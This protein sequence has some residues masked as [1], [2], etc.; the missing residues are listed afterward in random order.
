[1]N[2]LNPYI[3]VIFPVYNVGIYVEQAVDSILSQTFKN[4]E[5]III[6]DGSTDGSGNIGSR[7]EK[8]DARV[9]VINI[10]NG[11]L[12]NARNVGISYARG[13]Y[14]ACVD[15]DDYVEK[16]YLEDLYNTAIKYDADIV[17]CN[18]YKL[19]VKTGIFHFPILDE[20]IEDCLLTKEEIHENYYNENYGYRTVLGSAWA[21]IIRRRLLVDVPFPKGKIYEDAYTIYKLYLLA[22]KIAYINKSLYVYR[23]REG[24]IITNNFSRQKIQ[25][26]IEMQEERFALL[27]VLGYKI[28]DS[29]KKVY[30]GE[31]RDMAKIALDNGYIEEYQR[32]K[33]KFTVIDKYNEL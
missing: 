25:D 26:W 4:F 32:I 22:D 23:V 29:H 14:I 7:Y 28:T 1:M 30:L 33:N 15:S 31:M 5:L 21:K 20:T 27:T 19:V 9:K 24:S 8:A 13:E 11:G 12:A 10:E 6:N 16:T 18:Y 17:I 3:S 2:E